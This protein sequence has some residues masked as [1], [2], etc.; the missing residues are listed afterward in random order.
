MGAG[1]DGSWTPHNTYHHRELEWLIPFT[2]WVHDG[3]SFEKA[4]SNPPTADVWS[5]HIDTCDGAAAS[6]P[7]LQEEVHLDGGLSAP[8]QALRVRK[9]VTFRSS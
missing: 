7:P 2:G 3:F 1:K 5:G 4:F 6:L 8:A 9:K